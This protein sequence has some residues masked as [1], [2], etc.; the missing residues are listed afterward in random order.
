MPDSAE[1]I[2]L[3]REFWTTMASGD[4]EASAKLIGK[5]SAM[6]TGM[7]ALVFSPREYVEMAAKSPYRI[8]DW[9]FS[10]EKVIF[11]TPDTAVVTYK[12][13]QTVEHDGKTETTDNSD[14]S[15]WV[16]SEGAWTCILHTEAPAEKA[17][18]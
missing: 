12:V 7:G 18:G 17:P 15:V 5:Q 16:R 10:D 4:H 2:G 1:I 11:P 14:S 3:E 9:E 8:T 13:K 6:V